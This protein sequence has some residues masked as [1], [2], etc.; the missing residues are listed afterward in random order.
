MRITA[1]DL[2]RWAGTP[3]ARSEF[4]ALLR[5]LLLHGGGRLCRLEMPSGS[6]TG[7]PGWD[8]VVE[9]AQGTEW[10]PEGASRWEL[11]CEQ[12]VA[13]KAGRDFKKR[14]NET[15]PEERA[16]LAFVFATPRKWSAKAKW[17]EEAKGHGWREVRAYDAHALVQWLE[18][19]PAVALWLAEQLGK[20]G[21]GLETVDRFFDRW[22]HGSDPAITA[23][24]LATG[25]SRAPRS[26]KQ[27]A[28]DWL[29]RQKRTEPD[30]ASGQAHQRRLPPLTIRADS[31]E[32]AAAFVASVLQRNPSLST[33][34]AVVTAPEGWQWVGQ[35]PGLR[36][37]LCASSELLRGAPARD[38]LI[39]LVPHASG[40]VSP[41]ENR[42]KAETKGPELLLPRP[43]E[44]LFARALEKLGIEEPKARALARRCGRSW[45]AFRRLHAASPALRTPSWLERPEARAL[46][47]LALFG[48]FSERDADRALVAEV[49]GR[50]WE[51]LERDLRILADQPDPPV[52]AIGACWK[53]KA[54]AE[55]FLVMAP[56]I[57]KGEVD[58][59]LDVAQRVLSERDPALDPT[60]TD[61]V[62][63]FTA[64]RFSCSDVLRR[65]LADALPRLA[66]LGPGS[67]RAEPHL[68][69]RIRAMVRDLLEN[70][71][72]ERWLSLSD[73]LPALAEAAPD[74]FLEAVDGRLEAAAAASHG[75]RWAL[76]VLAWSPDHLGWVADL[77]ARLRQRDLS[78]PYGI[79]PHDLLLDIFR[80]WFP[81]TNAS[82]D[83]RRKLLVVLAEKYPDVVFE[84]FLEML[85]IHD[86]ASEGPYPAWRDDWLRRIPF[87]HEDLGRARDNSLARGWAADRAIALA[88]GNPDRLA[89]LVERLDG[90]RAI[91]RE[92]A[93]LAAL[94]CFARTNPPDEARV[95]LRS[96]VAAA[97]S[98]DER[99]WKK[100]FPFRAS[101]LPLA[102]LWRALAPRD[103]VARFAFLFHA[104]SRL[105]G[106]FRDF[107]AEERT[108]WRQRVAA[109]R[110]IHR[111]EGVPG[112]FRLAEAAKWPGLVGGAAVRAGIDPSELVV[113]AFARGAFA[114]GMDGPVETCVVVAIRNASPSDRRAAVEMLLPELER[115]GRP[116]EERARPFAFDP[117]DPAL[118]DLLE[119][120]PES[121]RAAVR[122]LV[123]RTAEDFRALLAAGRPA[124]A[125]N[126]LARRSTPPP[127]A[128]WLEILET[129]VEIGPEPGAD[130][131]EL[132]YSVYQALQRLEADP[133]VDRNRLARV[134]FDLLDLLGG[135]A[136]ALTV[137][138]LWTRLTADPGFFVELL[139]LAF[140]AE[141]EPP[142]ELDERDRARAER[143]HRLLLW[144]TWYCRRFP[145]RRDDGTVDP[146]ILE[147]FVDQAR[148]LA[149]AAGRLTICEQTLGQLLARSPE[150]P[151]GHWPCEPV[152]ALLDRPELGEVRRGFVIGVFN[153]RGVRSGKL[154]EG[155]NQEREL[156]ER[157]RSRA[158]AWS[159]RCP[160]TAATLR[161]IAD[162]Y[163]AEAVRFDRYFEE[164][165][166]TIA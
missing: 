76:A 42:E 33:R 95:H 41:F 87:P 158:R 159:A 2:D 92:E 56:R 54:I 149:R 57:T 81:Q 85:R 147:R 20:A 23:R 110:A 64:D 43:D 51:E 19:A 117:D 128:P 62:L 120:Q 130:A 121:V 94:A 111:L 25:R 16:G 109:V 116:A 144:L 59:F 53:A 88:E 34:A 48:A 160:R 104:H 139:T 143:A 11:S 28:K 75:L 67:L 101:A 61:D 106:H 72:A 119:A 126:A 129:L 79:A 63:P 45:S 162:R 161:R 49:A 52:L 137:Q 100:P 156:A 70:A 91:G 46:S 21:P 166:E 140:R 115:L 125:M 134:E 113:E 127:D 15:S 32:E 30:G 35:N 13:G 24:A 39:V 131:S 9:A 71:D 27:A 50:P 60:K 98:L 29:D 5:R 152:A 165:R 157:F 150:D 8:G 83:Q 26:L 133:S 74:E 44:L 12:D 97:I 47:V 84:I 65:F 114:Q 96:A 105:P 93:L 148:E 145:G 73:R 153:A 69:A 58:R 82:W 155:G 163:E 164:A 78:D 89:K 86:T 80:P 7:L 3:E 151:D 103:I 4:P 118:R 66:V 123:P 99:D 1:E 18:A 102:R 38:G 36:F 136:K 22:S 107:Y 17:L 142:R 14:T 108:G 37:V 122:L 10:I 146:K 138:S 141:G 68:E 132:P 31:E 6:G 90:L 154:D 124:A 135:D 55:L 112:I 40:D 77:L